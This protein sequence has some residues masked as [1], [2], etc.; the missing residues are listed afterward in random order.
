MT[1][2][3]QK[4]HCSWVAGEMPVIFQNEYKAHFIST[5]KTVLISTIRGEGVSNQP[6]GKFFNDKDGHA[7]KNFIDALRANDWVF[8]TGRHEIVM[9]INNTPCLDCCSLLEKYMEEICE[10][11]PNTML[12][13]EAAN[14]YHPNDPFDREGLESLARHNAR[15]ITVD[16]WNVPT[17]HAENGAPARLDIDPVESQKKT[18]ARI[19]KTLRTADVTNQLD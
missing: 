15:N 6:F 1:W 14:Q 19:R 13:I 5:F 16:F 3:Q 4:P 10:R 17:E 18:M 12:R 11:F 7:E 8:D 9:R 2:K